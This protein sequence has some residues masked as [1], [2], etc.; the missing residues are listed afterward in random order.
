MVKQQN[1]SIESK[2]LYLAYN[3]TI[4]LRQLEHCK[5]QKKTKT[6][7]RNHEHACSFKPCRGMSLPLS[8]RAIRA[9]RLEKLN[10]G[11][12]NF[13]RRTLHISCLLN[14]L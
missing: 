11:C 5:Q 2:A 14:E 1:K 6:L 12:R 8:Q 13:L 7:D 3:I 10:T 9:I 4:G